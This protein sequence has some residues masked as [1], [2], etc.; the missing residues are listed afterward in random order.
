MPDQAVAGEKVRNDQQFG[1]PTKDIR[2]ELYSLGVTSIF[3][4]PDCALD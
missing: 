1:E 4:L 3:Y 2:S